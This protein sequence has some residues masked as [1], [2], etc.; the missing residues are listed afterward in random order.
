MG[1]KLNFEAELKMWEKVELP[2]R[3]K[4]ANTGEWKADG[5]TIEKTR[6]F[7]R[8]EFGDMLPFLAGN[9]Y[10]QLEDSMVLVTVEIEFNDY[11]N[12][13]VVKLDNITQLSN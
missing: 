12:K 3:I 11:Q 8:D 2:N 9:E 5:T 6:Y 1:I 7:L 10:R 13:N 4:D